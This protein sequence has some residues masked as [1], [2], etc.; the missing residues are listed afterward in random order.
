A[1]ALQGKKEVG[2]YQ[3]TE[4][5]IV[6]LNGLDLGQ[7]D[8]LK[9]KRVKNLFSFAEAQQGVCCYEMSFELL[10][11][12][13]NQIDASTLDEFKRFHSDTLNESG[14]LLIS[15]DTELTE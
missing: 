4:Q 1:K 13:F 11:H 8:G 9:F 6:A 15:A 2:I 7:V 14:D 12:P 3:M 10:M 5:L